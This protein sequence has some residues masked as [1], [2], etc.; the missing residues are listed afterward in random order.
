ML[1][2]TK[3]RVLE[4]FYGID[5]V[6]FGK[7]ISEVDSCC[8]IL[9]EEYLTVKGA[10]MSVYIEML[11]LIDHIPEPIEERVEADDLL[12]NAKWAADLARENA[13]EIVLTDSAK[14]S[15]KISMKQA[16]KEDA[17]VNL[18]EL[19]ETKIRQKAYGL[20]V[21]N[22]LL[23]RTLEESV[24][25]NNMNEWEGRIMEDSYKVLRDDL[26]ERAWSILEDDIE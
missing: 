1:P 24:D 19:L 21:D 8:P 26:V 12:E 11:K 15:I 16:L 18:T 25:I 14:E 4:N 17:D 9:K 7:P 20:A 3:I 5:Y 10:L 13:K 23:A 6:F 2:E 22:L